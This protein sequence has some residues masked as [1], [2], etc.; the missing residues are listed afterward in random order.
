MNDKIENKEVVEVNPIPTNIIKTI[1]AACQQKLPI[2][3]SKI[4]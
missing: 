2:N 4:R 1:F 3:K